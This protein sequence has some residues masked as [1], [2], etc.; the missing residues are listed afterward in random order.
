MLP[1]L[2]TGLGLLRGLVQDG[3]RADSAPD[4]CRLS[5]PQ[6]TEVQLALRGGGLQAKALEA[7]LRLRRRSGGCLAVLGWEG[8]APAVKQRRAEAVAAVQAAGGVSLG[9][10]AGEA[11]RR[12][13]FDA[14]SQRDALLDAGVMVETLETA[15]TWSRLPALR[16]A[17]RAALVDSLS[18]GGTPPVVFAHVSHVY[19]T[20]ASVYTTVL[21]RRSEADTAAAYEQWQ[22]AKAAA[23]EALLATGGTLT[24]HHAVGRDHAPWLDREVGSLGVEVLGSVKR[25]LD[26][27]GVLNPGVLLPPVP[28]R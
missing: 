16:E 10:A 25:A 17:V 23:T 18:T 13:R 12:H 2:T 27:A 9:T 22:V 26:P 24:H 7:Y 14:P 4:V 28:P 21:A 11:W 8:R 15:T 5:D 19:P 20:G 6:E 1:D 3:P